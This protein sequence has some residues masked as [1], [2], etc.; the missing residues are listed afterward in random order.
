MPRT[1]HASHDGHRAVHL[2]PS[3]AAGVN[4]DKSHSHRAVHLPPNPA[5]VNTDNPPNYKKKQIPAGAAGCLK[6][7]TFVRTGT[8][9]SLLR[10]EVE[11]LIARYRGKISEKVNAETSF[12]LRGIDTASG[13]LIEGG[14]VDRARRYKVPIINEDQLLEMI[15]A[16]NSAASRIVEIFPEA[17]PTQDAK[18]PS[19]SAGTDMMILMSEAAEYAVAEVKK[20]GKRAERDKNDALQQLRSEASA[21]K[22]A[23]LAAAAKDREEAVREARERADAVW[24]SQLTDAR[25]QTDDARASLAMANDATKKAEKAWLAAHEATRKA[26]VEAKALREQLNQLQRQKAQQLPPQPPPRDEDEAAWREH[27]SD[28]A[29]NSRY[30]ALRQHIDFLRENAGKVANKERWKLKV[31]RGSLVDD[32]LEAFGK[33]NSK[34][35]L[36]RTT[37]VVFFG[38]NGEQEEGRDLGGLSSEMHTKFWEAVVKPAAGLFES[39]PDSEGGNL[40]PRADAA[41]E[42]LRRL[43][44]VLCKAVI[45]E[46]PIGG[47]LARLLF[48]SLVFEHLAE[49]RVFDEAR[50]HAALRALRDYDGALAARWGGLLDGSTAVEDCGLTLDSF[51]DELGEGEVTAANL[52]RAVV[53]GCRRRLLVGREAALRSLRAGFTEYVDL[54]LQLAALS[55]DD[56]LRMVQGRLTISP[57]EL[58]SCVTWPD[59][60]AQAAAD[61]RFPAG[62]RVHEYLR[63]LLLDLDETR[64]FRFLQWATALR[65]LPPGGLQDDDYRISLRHVNYDESYLPVAHTCTRVL[66][67]PDY[68]SCEALKEK[69]EVALQ[70][71]DGGFAIL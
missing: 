41:P 1:S 40:L 9:D 52:P 70:N 24:K 15:R 37:D 44:R 30:L 51:D 67:M 25:K 26:E 55:C 21:E 66:D 69:L 16:S 3:R 61:A 59:A 29:F 4:A 36:W 13:Q 64:C 7:K 12:L 57:D 19:T 31:R 10:A 23:A 50:P 54:T 17:A 68:S 46:H 27:A 2:A 49:R 18:A 5:A 35:L 45:D 34:G 20:A 71:A 14:K 43:G 28:E 39:S 32:V 47:G 56:M 53:A 8:M 65:A 60:S 6:G 63:A 22:Q 62:S 42:R 58:V 38:L 48:E 11:Q 33:L